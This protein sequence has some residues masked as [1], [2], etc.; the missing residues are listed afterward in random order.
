M[1]LK[2]VKCQILNN[3]LIIRFQGYFPNAM[4]PVIIDRSNK[5]L[6]LLTEVIKYWET[7][8][9]PGYCILR[10]NQYILFELVLLH[11]Y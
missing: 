9:H 4:I 7:K 6:V 5:T 2:L 8:L 3:L 11:K 10:Q 1:T